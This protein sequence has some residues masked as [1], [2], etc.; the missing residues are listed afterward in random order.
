MNS[1]HYTDI[2]YDFVIGY[3]ESGSYQYE[4][5]TS[6]S[7]AELE[8]RPSFVLLQLALPVL[9]QGCALW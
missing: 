5:L 3:G 6:W 2:K 7:T 4:L 8:D 1:L 9:G